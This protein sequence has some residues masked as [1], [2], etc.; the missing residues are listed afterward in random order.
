MTIPSDADKEASELP[1]VAPADNGPDKPL[2]RRPT[3]SKIPVK[4]VVFASPGSFIDGMSGSE[5]S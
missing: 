2:W 1:S 3:M 4:D 5:A